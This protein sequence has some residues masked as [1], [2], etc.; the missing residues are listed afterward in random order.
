VSKK[1][2]INIGQKQKRTGE[3]MSIF[4]TKYASDGG[5]RCFQRPSRAGLGK[6]A[7]FML[8]GMEFR[9]SSTHQ[10]A[11]GERKTQAKLFALC[12]GIVLTARVNFSAFQK[13]NKRCYY[14]TIKNLIETF[15]FWVDFHECFVQSKSL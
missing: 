5:R 2:P 12:K 8:G 10:S 6:P 13:P 14:S 4:H 3:I 9:Q 15:S 7:P 1:F 11:D